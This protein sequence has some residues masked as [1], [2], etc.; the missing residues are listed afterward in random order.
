MVSGGGSLTSSSGGIWPEKGFS[1]L[2]VGH[3]GEKRKIV[4][5]CAHLI[6]ERCGRYRTGTASLISLPRSHCSIA[7]DL[8]DSNI[9]LR[10]PSTASIL[11]QSSRSLFDLP[12]IRN[13]LG[14]L[15][16]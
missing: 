10:R 6:Q 15:R 16:S 3:D 8:W 1:A 9:F 13:Y 2:R 14:F 11:S 7:P 4:E 5:A 12:A